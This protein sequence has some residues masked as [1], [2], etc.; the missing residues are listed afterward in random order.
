MVPSIGYGRKPDKQEGG[1]VYVIRAMKEGEVDRG[2]GVMN[3]RGVVQEV[4]VFTKKRGGS[5]LTR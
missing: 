1:I 4:E 2:V 3:V 5:R